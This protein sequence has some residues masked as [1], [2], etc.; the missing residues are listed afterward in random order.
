MGV[1]GMLLFIP[2]TSVLYAL[3]REFVNRRLQERNIRVK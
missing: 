3:F 2:L 1:S